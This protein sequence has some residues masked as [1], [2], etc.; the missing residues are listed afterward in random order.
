[1]TALE[2][3]TAGV[4]RTSGG[5]VYRYALT[6]LSRAVRS[7]CFA[8]VGGCHTGSDAESLTYPTPEEWSWISHIPRFLVLERPHHLQNAESPRQ[9][10]RGRCCNDAAAPTERNARRHLLP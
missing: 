9:S 5:I 1:M 7:R 2:G 10:L 4:R 8:A 6:Y 3:S